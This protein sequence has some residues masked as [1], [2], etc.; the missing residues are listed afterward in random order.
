MTRRTTWA[1][2]AA[3]AALAAG[4]L[5]PLAASAQ[6]PSKITAD[7]QATAATSSR[8]VVLPTGDV[9]RAHGST[10]VLLHRATSGPL[11]TMA[12]G[13]ARY[14][15]P[16][17]LQHQVGGVLDAALF[18]VNADA[19][20]STRVPV[21]IRYASADA[22]TAVP[23]IEV[24]GRSGLSATGYVTPASSRALGRA[25][26]TQSGDALFA[27]VA[28]VRAMRPSAP[29]PQWP[30]HTV[31]VNVVDDQGKPFEGMFGYLNTTD[32]QKD[33]GVGFAIRGKAKISLPQGTW[34]F[35]VMASN[36][37]WTKSYIATSPE[38]TVNSPRDVRVDVRSATTPIRTTLAKPVREGGAEITE[39]GRDIVTGDY[40][41][42]ASWVLLGDYET[43]ETFVTPTVGALH[44]TQRVAQVVVADGGSASAP[45]RYSTNSGV[46]GRIP[47]S[48]IIARVDASNTAIY[49][50]ELVGGFDLA[51]SMYG[52]SA[53]PPTGGWS[54]GMPPPARAF[55]EYVST[56]GGLIHGASL[57]QYISFDPVFTEKGDFTEDG[58]VGPKAGTT[59]SDVWGQAPLHQAFR[60]PGVAPA[61]SCPACLGFGSGVKGFTIGALPLSD[62]THTGSGDFTE[63]DTFTSHLTIKADGATIIDQ[64]GHLSGATAIPDN[65]KVLTTSQIA[66]RSGAPFTL[67]TTMTTTMSIKT[68]SAVNAPASWWCLTQTTCKVL[69]FL[70][71]DYAAASTDANVLP[72][73]RQSIGL[74]VNQ[75]GRTVA[76]GVTSVKAWVSYDGRT[77]SVAPV[78]GSGATYAAALT[79][80]AAGAGRTVVGLKVAVTDSAGTT[81]SE[82]IDG[83][84]LLAR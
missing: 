78:T 22:P 43:G 42:G 3:I 58:H 32:A 33:G 40:F 6:A 55:T 60:S 74:T 35:V 13:K 79:V 65:T 51:T 83:A 16:A 5:A 8:A 76:Q 70:S 29:T 26:A 38:V 44:G 9:I 21:S 1:A 12:I 23:G 7:W 52:R 34:Q 49:R 77:W 66:S 57:T 81:L 84:F 48:P 2:T 31:T 39:Y 18:D 19:T 67:A 64:D 36:A 73:G 80:P 15:Y 54:V 17:A 68:S 20:G 30:M 47:A 50:T 24:T 62:R 46:T 63:P 82:Q 11:V 10:P 75:V 41:S 53:N 4:G 37:D 45:Y 14:V 25:L 72:A 71:V 69:P 27:G 28:S 61:Q 56:G 59:T